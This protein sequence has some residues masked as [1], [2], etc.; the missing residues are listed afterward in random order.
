MLCAYCSSA[1]GFS[2]SCQK[3]STSNCPLGR[4]S[5]ATGCCIHAS[6]TMMKNPEIHEPTKTITAENQCISF[7]IRFSP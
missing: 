7:E 6:V 5:K 3:L 2:S 4:R 1:H